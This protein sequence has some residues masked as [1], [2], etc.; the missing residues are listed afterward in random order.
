MNITDN[1]IKNKLKNVYFIWGRG[2]TTIANELHN[3]YGFFIYSTDDNRNRLIKLSSPEY[4]PWMCRNFEK[5]Y[6]VKDFWELPN[7]I[8]SERE[9][10]FV[11]EMTPMIIADL[12]ILA[13]K[14]EVVICEGD[15]DYAAVAP[16]AEH[17]VHLNNC[18]TCFDWFNR[19]D[20][21]NIFDNVN[22]RDDLSD[23]E[24][25][26]LVDKAYS[27]VSSNEAVVPDWVIENNVKNIVWNDNISK[28][29]TAREVAGYFGFI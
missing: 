2:K 3:K 29:E 12:M 26:A 8:I 13:S 4:Q 23:D 5:E 10:H 16:V 17:C 9:K 22:K 18:G 20:H 1:V 24:K 19:P 6:K 11:A 28:E 7:E 25:K 15:I 14:H 27:V 21:E